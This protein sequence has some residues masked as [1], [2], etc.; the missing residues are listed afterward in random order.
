MPSRLFPNCAIVGSETNLVEFEKMFN[1]QGKLSFGLLS[2][3]TE[4]AGRSKKAR[5]QLPV[6]K[7]VSN[8]KREQG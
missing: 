3:L 5:S 2:L 7:T 6:P 8:Q 1:K 4:L